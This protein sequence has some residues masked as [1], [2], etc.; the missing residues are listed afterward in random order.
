[1]TQA[2][3]V[4]PPLR[5]FVIGNLNRSLTQAECRPAPAIEFLC[6]SDLFPCFTAASPEK[7]R[8]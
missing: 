1:L 8:C 4:L 7:F 6:L 5:A 2:S 3:L